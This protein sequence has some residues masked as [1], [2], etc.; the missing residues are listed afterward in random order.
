MPVAEKLA[1][2]ACTRTSQFE[3]LAAGPVCTTT[4]SLLLP[5]VNSI[6]S[7]CEL[8]PKLTVYRPVFVLVTIDWATPLKALAAIVP[9]PPFTWA[10]RKPL[11]NGNHATEVLKFTSLRAATGVLPASMMESDKLPSPNGLRPGFDRGPPEDARGIREIGALMLRNGRQHDSFRVCH[12][13]EHADAVS[14][15]ADSRRD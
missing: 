7:V 6:P 8:T 11:S 15:S 3:P 5:I 13:I 1:E 12:V 14:R 10:P 2:F 9:V 4:L